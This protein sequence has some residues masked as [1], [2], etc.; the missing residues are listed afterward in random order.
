MLRL[1]ETKE[2]TTEAKS[3]NSVIE[4]IENE[5]VVI[6]IFSSPDSTNGKQYVTSV[7][8]INRNKTVSTKNNIVEEKETTKETESRTQEVTTVKVTE[9]SK[10]ATKTPGWIYVVAVILSTGIIVVIILILKRYKILN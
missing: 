10:T 3:D 2:Q 9:K 5:D 8:K 4:I 1:T 7:T 6:T